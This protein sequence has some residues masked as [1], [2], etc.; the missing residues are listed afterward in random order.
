VLG[1]A[2]VLARQSALQ[3]PATPTTIADLVI[4]SRR[5]TALRAH[6][7]KEDSVAD[8]AIRASLDVLVRLACFRSY[9]AW[10]VSVQV[11]CARRQ[12]TLFHPNV[13]RLCIK[14]FGRLRELLQ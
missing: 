11:S 5:D 9:T 8:T 6:M 10:Y 2:A 13:V 14:P 12:N 1:V 3:T 7:S 4:L